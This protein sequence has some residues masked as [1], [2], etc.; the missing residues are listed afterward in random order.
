[1]IWP[2]QSE[3]TDVVGRWIVI[4]NGSAKD[5]AFQ[6]SMVN[7]GKSGSD[8]VTLIGDRYPPGVEF[9]EKLF[10]VNWIEE[11]ES[12]SS[13]P[14]MITSCDA[15][16]EGEVKLSDGSSFANPEHLD[17]SSSE[18]DEEETYNPD[19]SGSGARQTPMPGSYKFHKDAKWSMR[20]L[21]LQF[22]QTKVPTFAVRS[23]Q[24]PSQ[25]TKSDLYPFLK[26]TWDLVVRDK[27]DLY[28]DSDGEE[29]E[30]G[31]VAGQA[32]VADA[33]DEV[34]H[35]RR[36]KKGV[37]SWCC[38]GGGGRGKEKYSVPDPPCSG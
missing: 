24:K 36:K 21:Q 14:L 38:G 2:T 5:S 27:D 22:E 30:E 18:D 29:E 23:R 33:G 4:D 34:A 13:D 11:P 17:A 31:V 28:T 1:M 8:Y 20:R 26:S 15:V 16:P 25:M 12:V 37:F 7:G 19:Q 3:C 6:S 10:T 35:Q 32:E 9:G